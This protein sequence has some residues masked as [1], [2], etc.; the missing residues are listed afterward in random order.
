MSFPAPTEKQGKVIWSSLTILSVAISLAVIG[1]ILYGIASLI[2]YL[3]PILLPIAMAGIAACLLEPLVTWFERFHIPR[4]RAIL[5]VYAII[6]TFFLQMIG[7]VIPTAVGQAT[8]LISRGDWVIDQ[9]HAR[10]LTADPSAAAA[11]GDPAST[12]Q[13]E[14]VAELVGETNSASSTN[15]VLDADI[16]TSTNALVIPVPDLGAVSTNGSNTA[17]VSEKAVAAK[18][19]FRGYL[20]KLNNLG[21]DPRYK[22]HVD[23]LI[24]KTKE[25]LPEI[26]RQLGNWMYRQL[27]AATHLLGWLIGLVLI[28]VYIFY[29]LQAKDGILANWKNYLPIHH[30][31][32]FRADF[33][34]IC[35]SI[36]DA[37]IVFFRGQILVGV[38]SGVLLAIGLSIQGVPYA[39]LIGVIASILGIVPYLGF[40]FSMLI[41]I[42][43]CAVHFPGGTQP[44]ITFFLCLAVHWAEGF[45]YQ[46]RIIGDRV[47]LHPMMIIVALFLGATLLGGLLGGLLAIPL[48][49]LIKTLMK[50]YVWVN[51]RHEV[52]NFAGESVEATQAK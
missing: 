39:L 1:G 30:E 34:F 36:S 42:I 18:S 25:A 12:N 33:I 19:G 22:K 43:V 7:T 48:A 2:S 6:I 11:K 8:E 24:R 52:E 41:A 17:S 5:L 3:S 28:P 20:E 29:F 31:S 40:L 27:E 47:G 32:E 16:D 51:Y 37:M 50:R 10:L 44:M 23:T 15:V 13:F 4:V 26:G 14:L 38:I 45:G 35:N 9:L 21:H 49:A 46:P